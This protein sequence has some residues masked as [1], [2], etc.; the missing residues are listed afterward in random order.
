MVL[1]VGHVE[2]PLRVEGD[3]AGGVQRRCGCGNP[4]RHPGV[5]ADRL[6]GVARQPPAAVR[7][8][9]DVLA[10]ALAMPVPGSSHL[11]ADPPRAG[12]VALQRHRRLVPQTDRLPFVQV[13][14]REAASGGAVQRIYVAVA[15]RHLLADQDRL[16]KGRGDP[17]TLKRPPPD[18][19]PI[20]IHVSVPRDPEPQRLA[21]GAQLHA[22]TVRCPEHPTHPAVRL[23][24]DEEIAGGI[25]SHPGGAPKQG[26][27]RGT[28]IAREALLPGAGDGADHARF[29][30]DPPHPVVPGVGDV[31]IPGGV[32]RHPGGTPEPGLGRGTAVAREALV[33]GAGDDADPARFGVDPPYPVVLG[34][35]QID[36]SNAVHGH[37]RGAKPGPIPAVLAVRAGQR[38]LSAED[39]PDDRSFLRHARRNVES[40][41]SIHPPGGNRAVR[42]LGQQK[43]LGA[44]ARVRFPFEQG[45]IAKPRKRKEP[46]RQRLESNDV[47]AA[48]GPR[49]DDGGG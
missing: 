16:S 24:R 13:G 47:P 10:A 44:T 7:P 40:G 14:C 15:G 1:P 28:V 22:D 43:P 11:A 38:L 29:G 23:V 18:E 31:D 17:P 45:L 5:A 6:Q 41:R 46:A 39:R 26:S 48:P 33:P 21:A 34:V 32:H 9:E 4:V 42:R 36:I 12:L 49:H 30:I 35:G 3:R 8:V 19:V 37:P 2:V 25:H 27:G 20:E